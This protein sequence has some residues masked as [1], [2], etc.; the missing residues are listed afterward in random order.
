MQAVGVARCLLHILAG[1]LRK[2]L[3]KYDEY[4]LVRRSPTSAS[5][6][7]SKANTPRANLERA[8]SASPTKAQRSEAKP[9]PEQAARTRSA[10][11][12]A[13]ASSGGAGEIN[14]SI[15]NIIGNLL[16]STSKRSQPAGAA[17]YLT[18]KVDSPAGI[19]PSDAAEGTNKQANQEPF[20]AWKIESND[21]DGSSFSPGMPSSPVYRG[22]AG[23]AEG[24]PTSSVSRTP[25]SGRQVYGCTRTEEEEVRTPKSPVCTPLTLDGIGVVCVAL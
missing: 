4:M 8:K 16:T 12:K 14:L 19:P 21:L 11:S 10:R 24:S 25:S 18:I 20:A 17:G 6:P 22:R 3:N 5:A 13:S 15:D 23:A 2:K 7:R 1:I 9:T